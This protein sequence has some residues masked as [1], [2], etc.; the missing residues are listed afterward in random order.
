MSALRIKQQ[1]SMHGEESFDEFNYPLYHRSGTYGGHCQKYFHS[2][3][4]KNSTGD[5]FSL[6]TEEK[7]FQLLN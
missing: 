2:A 5:D 4:L 6:A 1:Q 3:L 7:F